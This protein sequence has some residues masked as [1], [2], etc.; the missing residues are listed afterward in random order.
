MP[1]LTDG[2]ATAPAA[3]TT[4]KS[5][6]HNFE[7]TDEQRRRQEESR[8]ALKAEVDRLKARPHH[9]HTPRFTAPLPDGVASVAEAMPELVA[10]MERQRAK[11][12]AFCDSM[13]PQFDSAPET[14]ACP[15]HPSV[16]L[17]KLFEETCQ[18]SRQAGEFVAAYAP[19]GECG[20]E[21]ARAKQRAFWRR[22]GVPERVVDA[23]LSNFTV[24]TEDKVL[25]RGKV[26]EW[27]KRSG[28]FLLLR[29]TT[30]TGKGHL[31]SGCLKAQGNGLFITHADMLSDL[32]ASYTL[33]TTKDLLA[34]W[35][36]CELLVLDEFG[37]SPGGKDEE[38]MLY[39]VLTKRY[40]ERRPTI[41]T[42]N[43]GKD[44]FAAAIGYRLLDRIGEDCTVVVCAW[45]S[46]RRAKK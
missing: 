11:W 26:Q 13:R 1:E 43:L 15:Q 24:D 7:L 35:Q 40:E 25:A 33:H 36:E 23:T 8:L 28:V 12:A 6:G 14:K 2:D 18:Q 39:Q 27:I 34:T 41:I 37:L 38:P 42:T 29:G 31:A 32:R 30:G 21:A 46:H 20:G 5:C 16:R 17:V 4:M 3:P 10:A 22:R 9:D 19:C 45:E 44:E